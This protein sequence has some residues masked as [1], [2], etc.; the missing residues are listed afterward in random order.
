MSRWGLGL[1]VAGIGCAPF[2]MQD[3]GMGDAEAGFDA[4]AE[5]MTVEDASAFEEVFEGACDGHLHFSGD[6]GSYVE[7]PPFDFAPPFTVEAWFQR[8]GLNGVD[9][10]GHGPENPCGGFLR[11]APPIAHATATASYDIEGAVGVDSAWH[12][13]AWTDEGP[14][15]TLFADGLPVNSVMPSARFLACSGP[16]TVGMTTQAGGG[17]VLRWSTGKIDE[18]R[19]SRAVRYFEPFTPAT[20]FELDSETVSLWHF[21]DLTGVGVIG[22]VLHICR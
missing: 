16:V 20:R 18:L 15:A 8:S 11:F 3:A 1:L 7:L 22:D 19:I 6:A 9:V 2:T 10:E 12:H 21:D 17:P 13:I 4:G 14:T 5:A